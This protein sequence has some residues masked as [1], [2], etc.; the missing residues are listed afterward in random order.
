[1]PDA[2]AAAGPP[3]LCITFNG[4][5]WLYIY[6]W[7]VAKYLQTHYDLGS[8]HFGGT[9]AG[10]L[11]A[12]TLLAGLPVD[13][14]VESAITTRGT[15]GDNPF[16]MLDLL[17]WG[18]ERW[19]PQDAASIAS[20]RLC[21]AL[22][23]VEDFARRP[24]YVQQ[25]RDRDHAIAVLRGTCHLPVFGGLLP[26][27]V[28]G[29]PV[30][31]RVFVDNHPVCCG[32]AAL[33]TSAPTPDPDPKPDGT[34]RA[35]LQTAARAV[36]DWID[37]LGHTTGDAVPAG[38]GGDQTDR[39]LA[40]GGPEPVAD[41]LPPSESAPTI[42]TL[43]LRLKAWLDELQAG[44]TP[45][46][47]HGKSDGDAAT[48]CGRDGRD[49]DPDVAPPSVVRISASRDC[50]CGCVRGGVGNGA[51]VWP[52]VPLPAL[53][54]ALPPPPDVLWLLYRLGYWNAAERLPGA[55]LLDALRLPGGGPDPGAEGLGPGLADTEARL[56]THAAAP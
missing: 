18:I 47:P 12:A 27:T 28:D 9:S 16:T 52:S 7:G 44:P 32:G 45:T 4:C 20:G 22:T 43:R 35:W 31:D 41:P 33:P 50:S 2:A 11:V 24:L 6:H 10:A 3:H 13:P 38:A 36:G 34:P 26:Y 37:A 42:G 5:G 49:A 14:V 19:A 29:R 56:R 39:S 53:W 1:M 17:D 25:F 30:Y 40:V 55:P 54:A 46:P 21:V 23:V 15:H 51:A 8:V 48:P